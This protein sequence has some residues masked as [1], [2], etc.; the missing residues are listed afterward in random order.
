MF[1]N[2]IIVFCFKKYL[3]I[4]KNQSDFNDD[5]QQVIADQPISAQT[6]YV[7]NQTKEEVAVRPKQLFRAESLKVEERVYSELSLVYA[8]NSMER[9]DDDLIEHVLQYLSLSDKLRLECVSKQWKNA[10]IAVFR[11]V[12]VIELNIVNLKTNHN[13]LNQLFRFYMFRQFDDRLYEQRLESV[14]KKCPNITTVRLGMNVSLE[15]LSL[16]GRYCP[17][18][19]SLSYPCN[20][21]K[22]LSFFSQYG[23]QL[24]TLDLSRSKYYTIFTSILQ[25]CPN[26]KKIKLQPKTSFNSI[27]ND[28]EFLPK[29]EDI[30]YNLGI[31]SNNV[32]QMKIFTD[33]YSQ[34][35]KIFD[36]LIMSLSAEELK[37]CIECIARF[38]N[39]QVLKLTVY[40]RFCPPRYCLISFLSK[41]F[42][43][44]ACPMGS[45]ML[46]DSGLVQFDSV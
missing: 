28:N 22:V 3:K 43:A 37:T 33:K 31:F 36:L 18:L 27:S 40:P 26:L 7:K 19:K 12:F 9:F 38:E 6:D 1:L 44:P 14:F 41:F 17:Q 16:F 21:D 15:M 42:G 24:E 10:M 25:F 30:G 34:T 20:D 2:L 8:N 46:T 5:R 35:L 32:N 45:V 23:L 39:L 4:G 11:K 29:L 13:S